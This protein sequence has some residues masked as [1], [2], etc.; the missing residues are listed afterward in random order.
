MNNSNPPDC[1]QRPN[2]HN[3]WGNNT[4]PNLK[5][6][7]YVNLNTYNMSILIVG[8]IVLLYFTNK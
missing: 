3:K 7:K 8:I 5:C 4:E 1:F 6:Y 2:Y